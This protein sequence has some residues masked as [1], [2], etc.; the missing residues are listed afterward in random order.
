[1]SRRDPFI[2]VAGLSALLLLWSGSSAT[3]GAENSAA[4]PPAAG[5]ALLAQA[6]PAP[7]PQNVEANIAQLHQKLQ[8]TPAQEAPFSAV[9]NVMRD[10]ARLEAGAP[11]QP[12]ANAT[13]V[14]DLR[15]FIKYSE[16]E[17]SGLKKMLPA[18]E[19]LY[20]TLSPAQKKAADA[21]FRQGPGG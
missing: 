18:L 19:S 15:A 1:M 9:A 10:N 17:L 21:V 14:D 11:Q 4:S 12:P 7:P 16:L 6:Q 20:T 2:A 13:A 3:A 5:Q 8:I